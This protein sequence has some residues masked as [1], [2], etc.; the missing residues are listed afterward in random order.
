MTDVNVTSNPCGTHTMDAGLRVGTGPKKNPTFEMSE[1]IWNS[2]HSGEVALLQIR[3]DDTGRC[4]ACFYKPSQ[5][6]SGY[7]AG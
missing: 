4:G 6:N 5:N 7:G 2:F 3:E 1:R